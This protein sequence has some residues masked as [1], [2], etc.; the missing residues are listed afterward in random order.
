MEHW[1]DLVTAWVGN[2][3]WAKDTRVF[4]TNQKNRTN[5]MSIK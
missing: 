3:R 4:Q 5:P 1:R 2:V